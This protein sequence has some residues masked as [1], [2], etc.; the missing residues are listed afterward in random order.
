MSAQRA[1]FSDDKR[2]SRIGEA[3]LAIEKGQPFT[4][5][6]LLAQDLGSR[7]AI[8]Q[9]LSRLVRRGDLRRLARGL[10]YRPKHHPALGEL[11][12]DTNLIAQAAARKT[13]SKLLASGAQS[14]NRLGLTTQVPAKAVFYTD[15]RSRRL[16]LG[17]EIIDLR[18]VSPRRMSAA[19]TGAGPII[20]ALRTLG[21]EH[22]TESIGA[23]LA[24]QLDDRT[25]DDLIEHLHEAPEWMKPLLRK[26]I[27]S[28]R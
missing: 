2:R 13:G 4:T 15:G 17:H 12:P 11:I 20:E 25:K 22:A 8:D 10:Y 26:V 28:N 21:P 16:K 5:Q 9:T 7:D 6:E 23:A 3:I 14:A 1:L 24:K 27:S 18:H 19:E